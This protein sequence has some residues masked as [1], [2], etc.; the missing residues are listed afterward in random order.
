MYEIHTQY[1]WM[2]PLH[3][4]FFHIIHVRLRPHASAKQG[5]ACFPCTS[6]FPVQVAMSSRHESCSRHL[7]T[8]PHTV[9]P[10]MAQKD[11][12]LMAP[13]QDYR[14]DGGAQSIQI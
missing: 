13:D 3:M 7:Q 14:G 1:N 10:S 4:L 6:S 9:H 2:F 8:L 5:H 11:G 12:N